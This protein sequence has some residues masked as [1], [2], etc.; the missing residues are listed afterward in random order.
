[1]MHISA[2]QCWAQAPEEAPAC[3]QTR[4]AQCSL[5]SRALPPRCGS[6]WPGHNPCLVS[7]EGRTQYLWLQRSCTAGNPCVFSPGKKSCVFVQ[8]T[9]RNPCPENRNPHLQLRDVSGVGGP[10]GRPT[11]CTL[12]VTGSLLPGPP[13]AT[14][15]LRNLPSGGP[16]RSLSDMV[17]VK[18][19]TL[20]VV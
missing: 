14:P 4:S 16:S 7:K 5:A 20:V 11:P 9:E 12:H 13:S 18:D 15:E 10:A 3:A 8:E 19:P 2:C 17:S 6:P 1:M